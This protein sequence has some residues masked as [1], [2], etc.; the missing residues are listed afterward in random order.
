MLSQ[1]NDENVLFKIMDSTMASLSDLIKKNEN[2]YMQCLSKLLRKL[3]NGY[4][5]AFDAKQKAMKL[6][7]QQLERKLV[8]IDTD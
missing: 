8:E 7:F 2:L 3:Q 5:K 6:Q 1:F 4:E